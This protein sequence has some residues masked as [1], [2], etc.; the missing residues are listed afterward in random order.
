MEVVSNIFWGSD[1]LKLEKAESIWSRS[2]M[3]KKSAKI[4]QE[5]LMLLACRWCC[6]LLRGLATNSYEEEGC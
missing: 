6:N 5:N 4:I 2:C 3:L 1:N